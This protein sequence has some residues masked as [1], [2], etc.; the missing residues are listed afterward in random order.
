MKKTVTTIVLAVLIAGTLL[1]AGCASKTDWAYLEDKGKMTIGITLFAPMNYEDDNGEMTGFETEF[2]EAVCEKLGLEAEFQVISWTT[3]ETEL[4]SKNIDCIWNGMTINAER[5][6]T[7][8]ISIPYMR[9]KQIM[10]VKSENAAKYVDAASVAGAKVVAEQESAGEEV[11][12]TDAMFADA[13]YIPVDSQ[14]KALL[15]VLSGTA[16]IG[17]IDYVMSIGS[18]GAG[19][20]FESLAVVENVEFAPEEYGI[21]FRKDSPQTLEKVNDA[22]TQLAEEGTLA[23]ISA[24]YKLEEL[25]IVK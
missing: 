18:I 17:V 8:D 16:D 3:K 12:T 1:L 22:I 21:A 20:D 19:T 10:V 11:A 6:E 23:Q 5:Q 25:L 24:K 7:M 4:N 13:E 15:E 2:A 9:N 14:A